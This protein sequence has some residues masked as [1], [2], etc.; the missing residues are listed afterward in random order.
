MLGRKALGVELKETYYRQAIKNIRAAEDM[1]VAP[2]S[3]IDPPIGAVA[4]GA[5]A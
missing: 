1:S 4:D 2:K 5:P 3:Q